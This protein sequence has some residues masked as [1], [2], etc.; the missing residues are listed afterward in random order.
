MGRLAGVRL[1]E[2]PRVDNGLRAPGGRRGRNI[3]SELNNA[4]SAQFQGLL[5]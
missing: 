1:F 4:F 5:D 3:S 2:W